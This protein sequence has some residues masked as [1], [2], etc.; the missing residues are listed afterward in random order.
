VSKKDCGLSWN[1]PVRPLVKNYNAHP[2]S[3]NQKNWEKVE[4]LIQKQ[5]FW[6]IVGARPTAAPRNS[7]RDNASGIMVVWR[8][9]PPRILQIQSLHQ[10]A[11][12]SFSCS[13]SALW[14]NYHHFT[15]FWDQ[16]YGPCRMGLCTDVRL[17]SRFHIWF[18]GDSKKP[19]GQGEGGIFFPDETYRRSWGT[20]SSS[21]N[22][23]KITVVQSRCFALCRMMW[24]CVEVYCSVLQCAVLYC[25]V[26]Q[27]HL[28]NE[29]LHWCD[30]CLLITK[31]LESPQ[32][33]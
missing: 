22:P 4:I 19:L 5:S 23:S 30:R 13:S 25:S 29:S 6:M 17:W 7:G 27:Y 18:M 15:R 16:L 14:N 2:F 8:T 28:H 12:H 11:G 33:L 31:T 24:Q 10:I 26:L 9:S 3:S 21:S 1:T 20:H 32:S